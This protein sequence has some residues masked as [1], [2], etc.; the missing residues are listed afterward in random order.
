[1]MIYTISVVETGT[2]SY[3]PVCMYTSYIPLLCDIDTDHQPL[4]LSF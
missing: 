3:A 4:R 2:G 1:M